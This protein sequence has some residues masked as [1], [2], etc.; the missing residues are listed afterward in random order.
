MNS[1][2]TYKD[3]H[4]FTSFELQNL[5]LSVEWSSGY[6]PD[7]LVIAME[8][9]QTVYSAWDGDHLAGMI[10]AMDDGVM[11]AYIHY[12]LVEPKY[13]KQ[14]IGKTLVNMMKEH[15]QDYLRLIVIAYDEEMG[16][17]EH[18]GFSKSDVSSPLFITSLW[19]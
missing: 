9:F 15:Y 6:Y 14:G 18:C 8:H 4:H 12:L 16:F 7:R 1:Q 5:F 2:I 3:T 19:T 13:Q 17:Y 11:N 10:C